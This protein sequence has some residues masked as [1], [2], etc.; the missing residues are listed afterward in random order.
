VGTRRRE[1]EDE[2]ASRL[3]MMPVLWSVLVRSDV[4]Q[5][6]FNN[7]WTASTACTQHRQLV[8]SINS[9]WTALVENVGS[10]NLLVLPCSCST[11]CSACLSLTRTIFTT[12]TRH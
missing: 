5:L 6:R 3:N 2:A 12:N 1:S 4:C 9:L 10:I 8:D 7:L 11:S